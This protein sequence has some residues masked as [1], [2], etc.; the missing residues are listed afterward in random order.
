MASIVRRTPRAKILLATGALGLAI[1]H[2]MVLVVV[3]HGLLLSLFLLLMTLGC[4][5]CA[6]RAATGECL[7]ELL[8]MSALMGIVH[9]VMVLGLPGMSAHHGAGHLAPV[10]T[11][12]HQVMALLALLEFALMFGCAL[13]LHRARRTET[14]ARASTVVIAG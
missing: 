1:G 10:A 8:L 2:L 11:G 3:P 6:V 4:V 13:A 14:N 12:S 5:R 7:Q 9:V